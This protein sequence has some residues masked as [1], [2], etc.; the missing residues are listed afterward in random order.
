M[1]LG[2]NQYG[3]TSAMLFDYGVTTDAQLRAGT[4][5]DLL[6][7]V[8]N[9]T[10]ATNANKPLWSRADN[11]ENIALHSEDFSNAAWTKTD[12]TVNS[13]DIVA[14]NGTLTADRIVEGSAGTAQ[15]SQPFTGLLRGEASLERVFYIRRGNTDWLRVVA[16]G[17]ANA[18]IG[19]INVGSGTVGSV[20]SVGSPTS[21]LLTMTPANNGFYRVALS[22]GSL[23]GTGGSFT[24]TIRSATA[25]NSTTRV[26]N[27]EYYLWRDSLRLATTDELDI[28]TTDFPQYAGVN[29]RQCLVFNGAQ[30]MLSAST[31]ANI[32]A[33]GNKLVYGV[34][35]PSI[36]AG[37]THM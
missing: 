27:A 36:G 29:G 8:N 20:A 1:T 3:L 30:Y 34:I 26:N 12:I 19:W 11:E 31:L 2:L 6:G 7:L 15:L 22:A 4:V 16:S 5:S 37:T 33:A 35:Q 9:F 13:N 32:F 25:N 23:A 10:Q 14:P 18:V 24:I 17:V 21:P 28:P